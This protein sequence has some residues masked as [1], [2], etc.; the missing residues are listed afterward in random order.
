MR[1]DTKRWCAGSPLV[2][3]KG[4]SPETRQTVRKKVRTGRDQSRDCSLEE[5]PRL[6]GEVVGRI[7]EAERL[8]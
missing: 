4:V 8:C 2:A 1:T 3:Q 7:V 6:R 5:I